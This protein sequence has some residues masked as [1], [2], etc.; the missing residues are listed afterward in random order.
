MQGSSQIRRGKTCAARTIMDWAGRLSLVMLA[1]VLPHLV[2]P[3]GPL[4]SAFRTPIVEMMSNPP[5]R[6]HGG[7]LVGRAGHF[8]RATAS[9]EVDVTTPILLEMPRVV[10]VGHVVDRVIEIEIVVIHPV[11]RIAQ[12]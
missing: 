1:H 6:E 5:A 2:M 9:R 3:I 11:H 8:P 4:V 10:L 12:I 7:H